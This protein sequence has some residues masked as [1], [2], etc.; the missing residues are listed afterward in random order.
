LL[1]GSRTVKYNDTSDANERATYCI[2]HQLFPIKMM[3]LMAASDDN[4]SIFFY[5]THPSDPPH[6]PRFKRRFHNRTYS[7]VGLAD[8]GIRSLSDIRPSRHQ[9]TSRHTELELLP[10]HLGEEAYSLLGR[11]MR[12]LRTIIFRGRKNIY[13]RPLS[14]AIVF[15]PPLIDFDRREI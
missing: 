15:R 4:L 9:G 7:A 6:S 12:R 2:I 10:V 1:K 13:L 8:R 11:T 14:V 3:G 5:S